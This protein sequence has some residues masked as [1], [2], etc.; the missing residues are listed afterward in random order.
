MQSQSNFYEVADAI[1]NGQ[2]IENVFST[3]SN[4][5]HN[6]YMKP[7]QKY[8]S[9]NTI[10][11]KEHLADKMVISLCQQLENR[12]VDGQNAGKTADLA[13]WIEYCAWDLDWE[14]TFSQDMGFLKSGTD[15]KNTIRTGEMIMRYLGCVSVLHC[16]P[17]APSWVSLDLTAWLTDQVKIGQMPWLDRLLGKNPYC[18]IKFSTFE[19]AA[20]YSFQRVMERAASQDTKTRKDFLDNFL[21]AKE[22]HPDIVGY[23]EVV[24][25]LMMNVLAGADTTAIVQKAIAYN[26][27]RHPSVLEKLRAELDAANLAFPPTYEQTKDLPYLNAVIKEVSP[28]MQTP[29]EAYCDG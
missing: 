29:D 26:I 6:R 2:R 12:F 5:F 3:R 15:V 8:L 20:A 7:Y 27:L 21:E 1:A 16:P 17:S 13:D 10:L 4:T 19:H 11:E 18:P 9:M 14:L 28:P 24:S 22:Q 25:Y 23:N